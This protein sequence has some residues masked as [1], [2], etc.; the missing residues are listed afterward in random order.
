MGPLDFMVCFP[1]LLNFHFLHPCCKLW[2]LVFWTTSIHEPHASHSGHKLKWKNAGH[3]LQYAP[4]TRSARGIYFTHIH[5]STLYFTVLHQVTVHHSLQILRIVNE[6]MI[7]DVKI[8]MTS[9]MTTNQK[10]NHYQVSTYHNNHQ[11]Y[12]EVH[13]AA[14]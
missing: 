13:E 3:S 2:H 12:R 9:F 1:A 4:Q 8:H 6:G 11:K 5:S 10:C 14:F 7:D